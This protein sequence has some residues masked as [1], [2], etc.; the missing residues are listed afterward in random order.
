MPRT[1]FHSLEGNRAEQL[2]WGHIPIEKATSFLHYSKGSP[3]RKILY[4]L[5]YYNCKELGAHMGRIIASELNSS[6]F[7]NGVDILIPVPLHKQKEKDRGYN[8]SEWIAKGISQITGIPLSA[9]SLIRTVPTSTQTRKSTFE[10][11][12]NVQSAFTSLVN[13]NLHEKHVLLIDDVLT[14]GATLSS[15]AL[16]I[17]KYHNVKISILTLAIV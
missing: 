11:R 4:H 3:Y 13:N 17:K 16:A 14:T 8:Q 9:G 5:K 6:G 1:N 2:F 7:F 10:R 15:C 12:E